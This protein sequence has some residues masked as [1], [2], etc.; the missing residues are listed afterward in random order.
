MYVFP[1]PNFMYWR[2]SSW[3]IFWADILWNGQYSA[4]YIYVRLSFCVYVCMSCI[5]AVCVCMHVWM[6]LCMYA[7]IMYCMCYKAI[8]YKY[9]VYN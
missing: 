5:Y 3:T 9:Y 1:N 8:G 6:V 4:E 7:S 2:F